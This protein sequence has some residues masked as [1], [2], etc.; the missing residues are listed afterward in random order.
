VVRP[1]LP[2]R[3]FVCAQLEVAHHRLGDALE[4]R[5]ERS[6]WRGRLSEF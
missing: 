3:H 2:L 4:L 5:I 6:R 1:L